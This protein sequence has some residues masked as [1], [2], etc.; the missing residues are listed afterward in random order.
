MVH[1]ILDGSMSFCSTEMTE[2]ACSTIDLRGGNYVI[3]LCKCSN[4]LVRSKPIIIHRG[5]EG[6]IIVF[7]LFK[8]LL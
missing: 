5:W 3:L 4:K 8:L 2:I 1:R 7:L 6:V